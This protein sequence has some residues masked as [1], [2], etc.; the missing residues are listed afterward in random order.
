MMREVFV[1]QI[2]LILGLCSLARAACP[3]LLAGRRGLGLSRREL[4]AMLGRLPLR[5]SASLL[6]RSSR[7]QLVRD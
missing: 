1:N 4:G 3:R 7:R 6:N 5:A 2:D